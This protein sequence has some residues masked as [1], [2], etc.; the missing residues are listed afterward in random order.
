MPPGKNTRNTC[1][2]QRPHLKTTGTVAACYRHEIQIP[3]SL[4]EKI[5]DDHPVRLLD[6]ILDGLD[7]TAWESQLATLSI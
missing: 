5:P 3:I 1:A 2:Y 6:E 7:W 4:E